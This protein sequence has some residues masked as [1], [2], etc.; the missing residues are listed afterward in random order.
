MERD[1]HAA[2]SRHRVERC[3]VL[4]RRPDPGYSRD[5]GLAR[6]WSVGT[7]ELLH[8][9][10]AHPGKEGG[11]EFM[12]D[13]RSLLTGS[14]DGFVKRW[15]A[16]TGMELEHF[17]LEGSPFLCMALSPDGSMLAGGGRDRTMLWDLA[18]R[19]LIRSLDGPKG[20]VLDVAFRTTEIAWPPQA[21]GITRS[22]ST[23]FPVV[24]TFAAFRDT[25]VTC[26]L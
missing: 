1:P 16:R 22:G 7:G 24:A 13:G 3:D 9:L 5:D 20:R 25:A 23:R 19:T 12:P 10:S 17:R 2:D 18:S 8:T 14:Q 11:V 15:D 6:L 21:K 26:D 4:P